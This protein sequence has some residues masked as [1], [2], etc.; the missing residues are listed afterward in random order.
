MVNFLACRGPSMDVSH[1]GL[2][3]GNPLLAMVLVGAWYPRAGIRTGAAQTVKS[4]L[5]E[6]SSLVYITYKQK[7]RVHY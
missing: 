1:M 5:A 6:Q 2:V 4:G 7:G 3:M